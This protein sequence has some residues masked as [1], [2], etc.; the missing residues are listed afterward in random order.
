MN[1]RSAVPLAE[2][3][4]NCQHCPHRNNG[5]VRFCGGCAAR[6]LKP[7]AAH[8]CPVCCQTLSSGGEQCRNKICGWTAQSR[9]FTRVDTVAMLSPELSGKIKDFKYEAAPHHANWGKVFGRLILDWMEQH[10][11]DLADIDLILG[12]PTSPDRA[13]RR[14]IEHMLAAA[15]DEDTTGSWPIPSPKRPVLIKT[16][17]TT[18][19]AAAGTGWSDK[20]RA[21]REHAASLRLERPN[22]T[23]GRHILLIDDLLTTGSQMHTVAKFLIE[24]GRATS[25]RGLVLGRVEWPDILPPA[26]RPVR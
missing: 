18:R 26:T 19:S 22:V 17:E 25:V 20:M 13:P 1:P 12:N 6:T 10:A 21:A 5:P 16:R 8:H 11:G 23:A 7:V 2:A 3:F 15:Y 4:P 24:K 14:H 9:F